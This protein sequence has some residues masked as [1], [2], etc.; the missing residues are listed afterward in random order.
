MRMCGSVRSL[1]AAWLFARA[2]LKTW[3]LSGRRGLS[4]GGSTSEDD[5]YI[6]CHWLDL[7]MITCYDFE[8]DQ[9]GGI[10]LLRKLPVYHVQLLKV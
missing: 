7:Q 9:I 4:V 1:C 5:D 2:V 10:I 3:R 8:A 6:R